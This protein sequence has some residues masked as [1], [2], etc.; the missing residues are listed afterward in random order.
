MTSLTGGGFLHGD[1][2]LSIEQ[3]ASVRMLDHLGL[4]LTDSKVTAAF[5]FWVQLAFTAA[6]GTIIW[7]SV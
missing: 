7:R 3:F 6:P 4:K 1:W 5:H 2:E